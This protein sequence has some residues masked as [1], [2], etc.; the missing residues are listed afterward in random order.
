[1]RVL[2]TLTPLALFSQIF[3]IPHC[4]YKH[5]L[6]KFLSIFYALLYAT[7]HIVALINSALEENNPII[8]FKYQPSLNVKIK[9]PETVR[10]INI[11][12]CNFDGII[13]VLLPLHHYK[14]LSKLR[15]LINYIE[16]SI[17]S[18]NAKLNGKRV[19]IKLYT[20]K[21]VCIL[22]VIH[23]LWSNFNIYHRKFSCMLS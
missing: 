2:D 8:F 11:Y 15:N 22:V 23:T 17:S 7:G 19:S 21:V 10:T 9:I 14:S 1:M 6:F 4:F 5:K 18:M 12:Q 3:A 20:L 16:F 13:L